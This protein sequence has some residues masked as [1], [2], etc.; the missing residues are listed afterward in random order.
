MGYH[1]TDLGCEGNINRL[2]SWLF[3]KETNVSE[4][5]QTIVLGGGCFWCAEAVYVQ[6]RGIGGC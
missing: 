2:S 1:A 4:P 3:F 5:V 6:V